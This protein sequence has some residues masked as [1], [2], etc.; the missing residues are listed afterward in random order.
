MVLAAGRGERLGRLGDDA[1]KPLR[2]VGATTLLDWALDGLARAGVEF[3]VVNAHHRA[4]RIEAHLARRSSP[5]TLVSR[6]P[7]LLDTGGGIARALPHLGPEPFFT[8]SAKQAWSD[9]STPALARLAAA[10]DDA[11]MDA[12][13]LLQ[14]I[15]AAIGFDGPGDFRLDASGRIEPRG[16]RAAAPFAW[17]SIQLLHPRFFADCPAGPFSLWV[18]WRRAIA[19]GRAFGLVHDGGWCAVST[20]ASLAL[21]DAWVRARGG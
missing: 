2:P 16:G 18:P 20:A 15:A 3:A 1:P 7:E 11:A 9:G 6:E 5:R 12:L 19:A 8:V 13:L 10:W 21:A 17:T 14:P 4:E